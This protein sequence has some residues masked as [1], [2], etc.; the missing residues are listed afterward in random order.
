M[1]TDH[2]ITKHPP[3]FKGLNKTVNSTDLPAGFA[4]ETKN[5]VINTDGSLGKRKGFKTN[6]ET[7]K[8]IFGIE[9]F[10]N[11]EG[12]DT[13]EE[14]IVVDTHVNRLKK[15]NFT[16][17][18]NKPYSNSNHS[19]YLNADTSTYF[20]NIY[21]VN[22]SKDI[23]L[24]NL[25]TPDSS[26]LSVQQLLDKINSIRDPL[27]TA[28]LSGQGAGWQVVAKSSTLSD[29]K[30]DKIV[31][32]LEAL[33]TRYESA[34]GQ[35]L[36]DVWSTSSFDSL[37]IALDDYLSVEEK[38]N[39]LIK[40]EDSYLIP[41]KDWRRLSNYTQT[42]IDTGA[43][44]SYIH[45]SAY[46]ASPSV[47]ADG[48]A[49]GLTGGQG[50]GKF[51]VGDPIIISNTDSS[52]TIQANIVEIINDST[53]KIDTATNIIAYFTPGGY[54]AYNFFIK[55]NEQVSASKY[56]MIITSYNPGTQQFAARIIPVDDDDQPILTYLD[57]TGTKQ[58]I[59]I[60][61]NPFGN[62]ITLDTSGAVITMN[63]FYSYKATYDGS[64]AS[65][66]ASRLSYAS[67]NNLFPRHTI[68]TSSLEIIPRALTSTELEDLTD[69]EQLDLKQA[70][71]LPAYAH[72]TSASILN[73]DVLRN[74]SFAK[75]NNVLYIGNG[76]DD[77]LKYDGN[78]LYKPG[79]PN[80][81][82]DFIVSVQDNEDDYMFY[83]NGSLIKSTSN[84]G[85]NE[86]RYNY[87]F[88]FIYT[89]NK[90]NVITGEPSDPVEI[91]SRYSSFRANEY[92]Q[93]TTPNTS[94]GTAGNVSLGLVADVLQQETLTILDN[95]TQLAIGSRDWTKYDLELSG[96]SYVQ[97]NKR[98][99]GLWNW[100]TGNY[101]PT[102]FGRKVGCV[103]YY[104]VPRNAYKTVCPYW[105]RTSIGTTSRPYQL[106]FYSKG[107][108]DNMYAGQIIRIERWATT[109]AD[110]DAAFQ[111]NAVQTMGKF[112]ILEVSTGSSIYVKIADNASGDDDY[113]IHNRSFDLY[114]NSTEFSVV[115]STTITK[116]YIQM[117]TFTES[118]HTYRVSAVASS[119]GNDNLTNIKDDSPKHKILFDKTSIEEALKGYDTESSYAT[120]GDT[121]LKNKTDSTKEEIAVTGRKLQIEIYRTKMYN[122]G[123]NSLETAG[124]YYYA[125][126]IS[127]DGNVNASND[128]FEFIDT[129]PD[130]AGV[131]SYVLVDET[132][133]NAAVSGAFG[134]GVSGKGGLQVSRGV[135]PSE[136][137]NVLNPFLIFTENYKRHDPPPKGA[138]L[139]TFKN[140]LVV[141]GH[142]DNLNNIQYSLPF[143]VLTG[144]IGSEYFPSDDNGIVVESASSS[145]INAIIGIRDVMYIFHDSS[146]HSLVGDIANPVGIPFVVDL[147]SNEGDLGCSNQASV[148]EFKN[149]ALFLNSKGIFSANASQAIQEL[150]LNIKPLIEDS[151][152]NFQ[153]AKVF[154]WS[155][156]NCLVFSIPVEKVDEYTEIIYTLENKTFLYDYNKDAWLEWDNTDFTGGVAEF[157]DTVVFCDRGYTLD[158]NRL[159]ANL[160]LFAKENTDTSFN[161]NLDPVKFS[162][163]TNFESLGAPSVFKKF[164]R[165]KVHT[166]DNSGIYK[167]NIKNKLKIFVHTDYD[168]NY[169]AKLDIDIS[170][171]SYGTGTWNFFPWGGSLKNSVKTKLLRNKCKSMQ[172]EFVNENLSENVKINT[173]ELEIAAPFR[174][175]IKE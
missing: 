46:S 75:L 63:F 157:D 69:Q 53:I 115:H 36:P 27:F 4:E 38:S 167:D 81:N 125:G 52:A 84:I 7:D 147:L 134:D 136:S 143:N 103:T 128:T 133:P 60:Y 166:F 31:Q 164:L 155:A 64:D 78:L 87:I 140:C 168:K 137:D 163:S 138:I 146:I 113:H 110:Y 76:Q 5:A 14:L 97:T 43:G 6:L 51:E 149:Q 47:D 55:K 144:E 82:K 45:L 111:A 49:T 145:R 79:L 108:T 156:I 72:Y 80:F 160:N 68:F 102:A 50:L 35:P 22:D 16:V 89:D 65:I 1:A 19:L 129:T 12:N 28:S 141:S 122:P 132:T 169:R 101:Y 77:M 173:Y 44:T 62:K 32:T 100:A 175:E 159:T 41:S 161:D 25:G 48:T 40:T 74:A 121:F 58:V 56:S 42:N 85:T 33:K 10:N 170:K 73:K 107:S 21:D 150:S 142:P 93:F 158:T 39:L 59:I 3:V 124:Q 83:S 109:Y 26:K 120:G 61:E 70:I 24:E 86:F 57:G 29:V 94:L 67:R 118:N 171:Y 112:E 117:P 139:T 127:Y 2:K 135:S 95:H 66:P 96:D 8:G 18:Y 119:V 130:E 34:T 37:I 126:T 15:S 153:R 123:G 165:L 174:S 54:N 11:V 106:N 131:K 71:S 104:S 91:S 151:S 13:T 99:P 114:K 116:N 172:L 162:Y 148:I 152:L 88:R 9:S 92:E 98:D 17:S 30:F 90:G 154:N 20:Y 105:Y 23:V